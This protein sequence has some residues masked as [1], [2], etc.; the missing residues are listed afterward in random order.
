MWLTA[1]LLPAS[2]RGGPEATVLFVAEIRR[3]PREAVRSFQRPRAAVAHIP[4]GQGRFPP[5]SF[6]G[7]LDCR[8]LQ[9]LCPG[10]RLEGHPL[11]PSFPQD[12]P[13]PFGYL[14]CLSAH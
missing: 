5:M 12:L 6:E 14:E 9:E 8:I 11:S 10:L 13:L 4:L 2:C 7:H 1:F 3:N